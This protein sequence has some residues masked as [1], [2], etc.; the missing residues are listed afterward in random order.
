VRTCISTVFDRGY[1]E[2]AAVFLQ[3]FAENYHGEDTYNIVC[4]IPSEDIAYVAM[5]LPKMLTLPSTL[6]LELRIPTIPSSVDIK[7]INSEHWGTN[8]SWYRLFIGST[9]PDFDRVLLFDADMLV[10]D[11]VQPILDYPIA[12]EFMASFDAHKNIGMRGKR[13]LT[14]FNAGFFIAD[15]NWWRSSNVEE[16]FANHINS[17]ELTVGIDD[18]VLNEYMRDVWKPLPLSFNFYYFEADDSNV[19]NW[20]TTYLSDH[21]KEAIVLHFFGRNKPWNYS[22]DSSEVGSYWRSRRDE[23]VCKLQ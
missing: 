22:A 15:L 9:L 18:D 16:V 4:I 20:D 19:P 13:H 6:E 8:T 21:H 11:D 10:V 2:Q 1:L 3:T 17:R 14:W 7:G 23:L 5:T 12:S